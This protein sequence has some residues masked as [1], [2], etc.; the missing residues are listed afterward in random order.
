MDPVIGRQVLPSA[1]PATAPQRTADVLV[2]ILVSAGV[3][4]VFGLPGGPISPVHDALLDRSDV[5]VLTTR[6]E[7]GA[8]FAAAGYAQTSGKLGVALVTSGPGALNALTG[9]ASANLDGLPVLLLVGEVPRKNQGRG[10]L[11]DGSAHGLNIVQMASHVTK[12]AAQVVEPTAAPA[13][14]RRAI[15]TALSGRRGPVVLTLPMDTT[16][17]KI[18]APR[19]HVD[20]STVH[21]IDASV[22]DAVAS[23][24]T[25]SRRTALLVGAGTRFG[26]GPERLRAF[27]ER[28]Q[29]P[30]ITTPKGKG[31]FPED[32]PLSLGVFGIGGHPSTA[33]WLGHGTDVLLAVGTSL[34]ELQTDGWSSLLKPRRAFVHVDIDAAAIGR[35]Y[36]V[37][38]GIAAPADLF[39]RKM[40]ERLPQAE[41]R[42]FGGIRRHGRVEALPESPDGRIAP[43]RALWEIQQVLPRDTIYTNDAGEHS[44]F[45]THYL[46]TTEPDAFVLM[47]GLGSM[48]SSIGAAIGAQLARPDRTVAAICGDGCFAMNAFEIATAVSAR[49]PVI[50]FVM[51]DERLAMVEMG[52]RAVYGR[53][54][55][56][57]TTPMDVFHVAAALGADALVARH[58]GDI[59]AAADAL[60]AP[61]DRPLVVDVRIDPSVVMP[62]RDR[63]EESDPKRILRIMN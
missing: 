57:P 34:G 30:V 24:I 37:S 33:A 49:L 56:Y 21:T 52:H 20:V 55:S 60:R 44:V 48:G 45:S 22:L 19:V 43:P 32:H 39:F 47:N 6:H 31:V 15:A 4:V 61:R 25:G 3:E 53:A 62:R 35:A 1:S 9:L 18:T 17:A 5:R 51:N 14:L 38:L 12:L 28:V 50:V 29:C 46:L 23:A 42:S 63:F 40:T 2:E 26:A 16:L 41:A 13:M 7:S 11:Q 10:A 8:L 58:A 27:A 59:L 54:P 36:S